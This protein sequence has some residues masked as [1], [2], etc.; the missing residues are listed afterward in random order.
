[1]CN[2]SNN[3]LI[4]MTMCNINNTMKNGQCVILLLYYNEVDNENG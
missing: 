3:S 2:N 1:M 4:L